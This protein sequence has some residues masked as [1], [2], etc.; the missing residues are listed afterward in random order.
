M[1]K[2][3][4]ILINSLL[5]ALLPF[6]A[7]S[8]VKDIEGNTYRTVQIGTQ[9][10]MAENLRVERFRDSITIPLVL[11]NKAWDNL[12]TPGYCCYNNTSQNKATYGALYNWYA[13]GTGKLCPAGWHVPSN[14][15]WTTLINQ[16]G[17]ESVAGGALKETGTMHW[18]PPN[19]GATNSSGFTAIPGGYRINLGTFGFLRESGYWWSASDDD[20]INAGYYFLSYDKANVLSSSSYKGAGLYVRCVMD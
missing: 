8:Q 9:V 20:A 18:W 12:I 19:T 11:D 17:G 2:K 3:H 7:N 5:V 16:L 13:V 1:R 15:E 10:W 14:A 4:S 6:A